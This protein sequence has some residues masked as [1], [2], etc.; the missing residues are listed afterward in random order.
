LE[1]I[2]VREGDRIGLEHQNPIADP[3]CSGVPPNARANDDRLVTTLDGRQHRGKQL[4][5]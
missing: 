5:G 2:H 3:Y 4:G 1:T